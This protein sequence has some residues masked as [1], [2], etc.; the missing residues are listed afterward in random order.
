MDQENRALE[1]RNS[2]RRYGQT[3][4]LTSVSLTLVPGQVYGLIG[5]NNGAGVD[6]VAA[7][8]A[9]QVVPAASSP[10]ASP[11]GGAP[12]SAP[13]TSAARIARQALGQRQGLL[14]PFP[15]WA[16][17][18]CVT[19]VEITNSRCA[20]RHKRRFAARLAERY[21]HGWT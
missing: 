3:Q 6:Q 15:R 18:P 14:A 9:P 10:T 4:A 5:Y 20:P 13:A 17:A 7:T 11:P 19:P 21:V 1:A 12:P 8:V 2:S 16:S